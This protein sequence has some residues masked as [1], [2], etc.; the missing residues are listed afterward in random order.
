MRNKKK[1]TM[2]IV[3]YLIGFIP[4]ISANIIMTTFAGIQLEKNMI[5]STYL[6]LKA[7]ATSVEQYFSWD[8]REDILCKD[9]VSYEFIDSLKDS[10]IEQ[11]FFVG[12]TRY[13]SSLKDE[14]GERIEGTQA[15]PDIWKT[16]SAGNEYKSNGVMI[17]G[18][19]YYA[20]YMPVYT[21]DGSE[22]IGMAFAGE[23]V[24]TVN[25][26]CRE[27]RI[28]MYTVA[29]ILIIV[30]GVILYFVARIVRKP[31]ALAATKLD[32]I[33]NGDLTVDTDI[34][35][36]MKE[37]IIL[38]TATKQLQSKLT[39]IISNVDSKVSVLTNN[40]DSLND[41]VTSINEGAGQIGTTVDELANASGLLAESVQ[42][43]NSIAINMGD[44][45]TSIDDAVKELN[46]ISTRMQA[47]NVKTVE[48]MST[49]LSNSNQ[50]SAIVNKIAKQVQNTNDA[51]LKINDAVDL[52]MG[53]TSQTNLLSLNASIEAARAGE[54]GRGFAV[55]AGEI[56][57][58][59]E[60]SANSAATIQG[61]AE[62]IL[63]KSKES[64][65]L[66]K[67]IQGLIAEEQ[68]SITESQND[69]E[70]LSSAIESSITIASSIDSKTTALDTMKAEV[71]EH[72][73]DLSAISQE[74]AASTEEVNANVSSIVASI[75]DVAQG[76]E[77]IK[78]V[79]VELDAL[80]Q[81]FTK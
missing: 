7:C 70:S 75:Q 23:S 9:D 68:E 27:L 80:M 69:F 20:Y 46:D 28:L 38:I 44:N 66:A 39:E 81:Y 43:V 6:R 71:I 56:K 58:L 57:A 45:I 16:V 67:E 12:D 17:A 40:T 26:T 35:S 76:T 4:L 13:L 37:N 11:T 15:D 3:I 14:S 60:Q 24:D 36:I 18:N 25:R 48:S 52:I 63:S 29:L 34:K 62:D 73:S 72:I 50:S 5:D 59:S 1:L 65:A 21:E 54:A 77:E 55:V 61:I 2:M 78:S 33:A 74:N 53:I 41:Q 19:E 47:A 22:V 10:D 79:A 42:N 32:T 51:V 64:V 8:I 30:F 49:V 31:M